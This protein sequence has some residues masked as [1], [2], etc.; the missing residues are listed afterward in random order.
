MIAWPARTLRLV[1]L[2]GLVLVLA[3]SLASCGGSKR[4][5]N[6]AKLDPDVVRF[7]LPLRENPID[8]AAAFRCYGSCQP[9]ETPT[10]YLAC[11]KECPAFDTTH[12]ITCA[13]YE[14][15]PYAACLTARKLRPNEELEPGWVIVGA[16]AGLAIIVSLASL[17]SSANGSNCGSWGY[18]SWYPGAPI[19]GQ[20][21]TPQ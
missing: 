9:E 19:T 3:G 10:S 13:D 16:I 4:A 14:V 7:R 5:S 11:L 8:P 18:P 2:R 1:L 15:P 21:V 20:P 6:G 17:C 12:G